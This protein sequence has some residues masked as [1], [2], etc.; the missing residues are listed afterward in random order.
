MFPANN[1]Q[2]KLESMQAEQVV[3]SLKKM[4]WGKSIEWIHKRAR[5]VQIERLLWIVCVCLLQQCK[6]TELE[7]F[8]FC[9]WNEFIVSIMQLSVF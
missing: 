8:L 3:S 6:S 9:L 4:T 1:M 7:M 5:I 2:I